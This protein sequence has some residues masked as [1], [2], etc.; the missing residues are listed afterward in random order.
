[1]TQKLPLTLVCV[2]VLAFACGPRPRGES[3]AD[4][5]EVKRISR[6]SGTPLAPSLDVKV[7]DDVR[8][9]FEV[10]NEGAKKLELLFPDGR[11]HDVIVLDSLGREVWRWSDGRLFTQTVQNRVLRASDSIRFEESWKDARPGSYT[12]VATL[13]SVNFP[14][15]HRVEFTVR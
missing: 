9:A 11:T 1:M 7:S 3:G 14:L 15:E 6:E 8:F 5:S 2:A 13:A 12:A 10:S 4:R